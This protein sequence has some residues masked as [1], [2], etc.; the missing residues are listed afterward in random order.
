M[1]DLISR[2][3]A[4]EAICMNDCG[5][6]RPN[7]CG[8]YLDKSC[9]VVKV[10]SALPSAEN[11]N[12]K[13]QNSNQETQKSN[14]DLI[15]RADAIEAVCDVVMDE[16]NTS[17]TWGYDVAEKA[18]EGL[19]SAEAVSMEE[20]VKELVEYA[21]ESENMRKRNAKLEVMLNAYRAISSEADDRLYIKI[22]ADDEPSVKAEKLYQICGETQN[23]EVTE[24]LKEYFP[25]AETAQGEWKI[26]EYG[27]YHCPFC[28]A[29]NNTVYKSFCP[30]CGARM[31]GGDSE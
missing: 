26:D 24:W 27:I 3:D 22:Y 20:H 17:A 5:G 16:F 2:A 10:L 25:S 6:C 1:S 14:G 15:N 29:I 12:A 31:K 9:D 30:N 4:I 23:R 18:I 21:R 8:A 7:E 28:Q 19:P 13:T 11:S